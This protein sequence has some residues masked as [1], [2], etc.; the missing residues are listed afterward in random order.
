MST[1]ATEPDYYTLD[2][3]AAKWHTTAYS[4]RKRIAK[5]DLLATKPAGRWLVS[6]ADAQAYLRAQSNAPAS[7]PRRTRLPQAH[8]KRGTR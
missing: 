6:P 1:T 2:D 4:L 7:K 8:A 5:G 3:L